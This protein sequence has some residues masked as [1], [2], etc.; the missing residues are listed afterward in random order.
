MIHHGGTLS[1][2]YRDPD[3]NQVELQVDALTME[4]TDA[5]MRSPVFAANPI[6]I[7]VDFDDL[8]ARYEAVPRRRR[9]LPTQ[10]PAHDFR[11]TASTAERAVHHHR[12]APCRPRRFRRQRCGPHAAP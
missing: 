12:P 8:I 7:P 5:L 9:F 3:G 4:D 11:G 2:Y 1:A 10:S 6:G